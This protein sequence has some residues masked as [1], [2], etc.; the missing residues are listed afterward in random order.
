MDYPIW[1]LSM[2]GGVLIALVAVT[3]VWVSHFAVGGGLAIAL[4]E[5]L[6]VRRKDP[7]LRSLARHR[8]WEGATWFAVQLV[9]DARGVVRLGD[10][11]QP[12][13]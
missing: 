4:V 7:A 2:G 10:E 12:D 11:V 8:K 5:T 3:H 13:R 1:D 9:P 6:G